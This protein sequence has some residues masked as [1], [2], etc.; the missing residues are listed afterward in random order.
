MSIGYA[1]LTVGVPNTD[2]RSCVMRNASEEKLTELIQYNLNSLDRIIDYNIQNDIK[3]FR[4]SSDI[5]PFA[6]NTV[7]TMPWWDLF[8][9]QLKDIGRKI[10]DSQMRVS[11][12]PGQYTVLNSPDEAVVS[13]AIAD[14]QYHTQFLD[15]LGVGSECKIILH[16]GGVYQEKEKATLRFI[17]NYQK[18]S[19]SIKARLVIEN[20][21]KSYNIA[22]VLAISEKAEIPVIYDNLHNAVN[23]KDIVTSDSYWIIESSH[24]WKEKD[25]RQKIHYSQQNLEK[26]KGAHS[27]FIRI[28]E[29]MEFFHDVKGNNIDIML[30]VKDKNLSAVKCI[31]ATACDKKISAL[32]LEWSKYKYKILEKSPEDY[33][34]I[35]QL[36][37]DKKEY[38]AAE[39]YNLVEDAL[40]KDSNTGYQVNAVQHV[41]GYFKFKAS[42]KEKTN[43]WKK[44]DA[45]TCGEIPYQTVKNIL[46]KLTVKYQETYLLNSYY[47]VL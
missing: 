19:G 1:C 16:I 46:W 40:Q 5:I 47:F 29:F 37:R 39:F 20:D 45:F 31:N 15:S 21:D 6:S 44:L 32:E 7:N 23:P 30:E 13:R 28:N 27:E 3:L 22:D 43:L 38:P 25:G 34:K 26:H 17:E 2:Q 4:I 14:L 10:I 11:M 8:D 33:N 12:H 24:T 9:H 36:L 18:L 35:R 41:W 42:E